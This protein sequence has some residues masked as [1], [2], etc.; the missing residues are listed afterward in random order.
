MTKEDRSAHRAGRLG[1]PG[2]TCVTAGAENRKI[3]KVMIFPGFDEADF[4]LRNIVRPI[5]LLLAAAPLFLCR[6]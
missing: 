6:R 4:T 1:L 2:R 5:R 3:G